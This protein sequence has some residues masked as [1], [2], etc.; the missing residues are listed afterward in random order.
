MN[1]IDVDY[2]KETCKIGQGDECC[3]FLVMGANGFECAKGTSTQN[4]IELR[5]AEG[6][7]NAKGDNCDG[8]QAN[9]T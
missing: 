3:A 4:A 7:M 6:A 9:V 2:T 8:H 1:I 5:L